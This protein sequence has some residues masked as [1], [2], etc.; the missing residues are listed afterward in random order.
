MWGF[1]QKFHWRLQLAGRASLIRTLVRMRLERNPEPL[2]STMRSVDDMPIM[3]LM[4]FPEATIL[5][6]V[7]AYC[8][9]RS[10]GVPTQEALHSIEAR[11]SIAAMGSGNYPGNIV[12]YAHYRVGL[13]HGEMPYDT[14]K[15]TIELIKAEY[16]SKFAQYL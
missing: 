13:E 8:D 7:E 10:K 14:V 15:Q 9:Q 1:F 11:R 3:T 12:Q 4:Q 16:R 6:I 5:T 2:G